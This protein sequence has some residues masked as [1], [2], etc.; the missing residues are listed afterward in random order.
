[1]SF[2][3][4]QIVEATL[5]E[6]NGLRM[7]LLIEPEDRQDQKQLFYIQVLVAYFRQD[8]NEIQQLIQKFQHLLSD[9]RA[10]LVLAQLRAALKSNSQSQTEEF[11]Y[12]IA[13]FPPEAES[14]L[15]A[16]FWFIQAHR[17][18]I[19][20]DFARAEDCFIQAAAFYEDG[21]AHRKALRAS[22]SAVASY[23]CL[24]PEARLFSE[25]HVLFQKG[26]E[27]RDYQTAG[28]ALLN[29]SREFQRLDSLS[30]A[31]EYAN[32]ALELYIKHNFGAREHGLTLTHRSQLLFQMGRQIEATKDLQVAATVINAEVQS[33]VQSL[34]EKYQVS[35]NTI[36]SE[37]SLPTWEER[38]LDPSTL[39][40]LGRLESQMIEILSRGP[41]TK[42]DLIQILYF[43]NIDFEFKE[44]R[45]KNLLFRL[46]QRFPGL[47]VFQNDM[48]SISDPHA[49]PLQIQ[50][51]PS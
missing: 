14:L 24:K 39:K 11:N 23:S 13:K 21:R 42:F 3:W 26:L 41:T 15:K 20:K 28:A 40:G 9:D 48:Y 6:L 29:I 51:K 17:A 7:S 50:R 18:Q 12:W 22:F 1:M 10:L 31:L 49:L 34:A 45:F 8:A 47:I 38:K 16:E 5:S 33:S 19:S 27:V 44:G 46:R 25:Y 35:V 36:N 37:L 32:Q 2:Q 43:E 4:V 30:L